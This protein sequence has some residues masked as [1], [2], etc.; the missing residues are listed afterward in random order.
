MA[1][2]ND[3]GGKTA[4][5]RVAVV[6]AGVIS[7]LGAGLEDTLAS[8][9]ANKDCVSPVTRFDVDKCRCK[10]AGQISDETLRN[11]GQRSRKTDRLH[12]ATRMMMAVFEELFGQDPEF[13]PEKTVVGTTS[14]GMSFGQDYY[15]A[16]RRH[17]G[18]RHSPGWIANYPP[19]KPVI[20]AQNAFK[21]ST[22]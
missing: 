21:I 14:G 1:R 19:Q 16:L 13:K 12:R 20:D 8:L 5:S 2:F 15:R 9:R 10:T 7:P 3:L 4:K 17:Q 22:P 18:L 6:A 11:G